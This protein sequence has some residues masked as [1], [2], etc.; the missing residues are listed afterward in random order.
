VRDRVE[1]EIDQHGKQEERH[2]ERGD[3]P[4]RRELEKFDEVAQRLPRPRE[5][6]PAIPPKE[7]SDIDPE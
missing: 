4:Q 2:A 7:P 5:D 3:M 1:D 6:V